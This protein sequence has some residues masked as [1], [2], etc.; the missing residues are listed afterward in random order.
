MT[1]ETCEQLKCYHCGENCVDTFRKDDKVFCCLGCKTVYEILNDNNLCDYYQLEN[2]HGVSMRSSAAANFAYLDES[3]VKAKLLSFDS[4]EV[5][6]VSFTVPAIHCI[7]C[8][9]LLE[10]L[11]SLDSG[12]V[13]A[14][15]VFTQKVINITFNPDRTS[16]SKIAALLSSL[17]YTPNITLEGKSGGSKADRSLI[18]KLAIAGFG[19]AN[20]MLFSFPEYL[21]ISKSEEH[22]IRIFSWL[23]FAIAIPV[24]A[25]SASDYLL[26]AFRSFRLR[27]INI[28]IPIAVGLI[29]L[30]FRSA[31]DII[32][33]TGPG[34][35]DSLTGLIFFLLI[36]RWFQS[37]TYEALAFDRD[38]KSY[39]PLAVHRLQEGNWIPVLLNSLKPGDR[40]QIRNMEIIP[41]DSTLD[42]EQTLIDYSFVTGESKPVEVKRGALAYAG[43][44]IIGAPTELVVVKHT[45]QSQLT[46]LWNNQSFNKTGT[47]RFQQIMDRAARRFTWVVLVLALATSVFWFFHEPAS[48]WLVITSVLMVA[49]PCALALATPFT[50]GAM[51]RVLGGKELYLKNAE[52]IER[53]GTVDA[54][55]FDKTGTI[56]T[57]DAEVKF[58]GDEKL[59]GKIRKLC[60]YSTH[61]LSLQIS[62]SINVSAQSAITNFEERPGLGIEGIVDGKVLKVGSAAF[63]DLHLS[64]EGTEK[65]VY[66]TH[67]VECIGYFSIETSPRKNIKGL[68]RRLHSKCHT[69]LSG[70]GDS[71]RERMKDL[72]PE[73]TKLIFNQ[74]PQDK[75]NYIHQ[76]QLA[77]KKVMMIGDGLND[78]GALKQADV[79]IAVSDNKGIFSPACDGII[80]GDQ[81]RYIDRMLQFTRY[82]SLI[83]K[84]GFTISFLYNAVAL[85]VAASGHLT[86][87]I[88]AIIMPISSISVVAFST[89]AV[90]YTARKLKLN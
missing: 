81:L 7:S 25:F 35:L 54:I 72:F 61:P 51:V 89:L 36:G 5:S 31:Y 60:S 43:G 3:S 44:R 45:S 70:D 55:V 71:D 12:I 74:S 48:M 38:Y 86:P 88:A 8:V 9:W 29:A 22:L 65:R 23:N 59:L 26:Q 28:D 10:K 79:G 87:L 42:T 66:V 76:L 24:F 37:K 27:Q 78:A 63:N 84:I 49:C 21:G 85:S 15:V 2:S 4:A 50:L 80:S 39:F 1:I 90:R 6:R 30:F 11:Q 82:S 58:I 33:H 57:G 19:F 75:M 53:M 17:G 73:H 18:F 32:S 67:D 46:S 62:N 34:Y 77:G 14:E 20:I 68:L 16:L 40:I 69:M 47:G 13:H 56:T 52:V 41:A 64:N 83:L